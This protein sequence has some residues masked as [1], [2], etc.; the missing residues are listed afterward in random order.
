MTSHFQEQANDLR[1]KVPSRLCVDLRDGFIVRPRVLVRTDAGESI[2]HVTHGENTRHQWNVLPGEAIRVAQSVPTLVMMAHDIPSK[3]IQG[4]NSEREIVPDGRVLLSCAP[5]IRVE[6]AWFQKDRVGNCDLP[7]ILQVRASTQKELKN[8][9]GH[10]DGD[11]QS[12]AF[13]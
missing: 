13:P 5:F 12:A 7:E 4:G 8:S 3:W 11:V 2:V 6:F 9:S 10:E 1:I